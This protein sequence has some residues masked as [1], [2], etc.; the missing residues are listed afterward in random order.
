MCI[1]YQYNR[2]NKKVQKERTQKTDM[3]KRKTERQTKT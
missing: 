2:A 3:D 1:D